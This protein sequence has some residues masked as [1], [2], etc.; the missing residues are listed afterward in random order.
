[1]TMLLKVT[2]PTVLKQ[3]PLQASV[4]PDDQKQTIEV[5]TTLPLQSYAIERNHVKFTLVEPLLLKADQSWSAP[6][7]GSLIKAGQTWY[8]FGEHVQVL[9]DKAVV[10]PAQQPDSVK[11]DVPYKSQLDNQENPTGSCNVTSLAMC[12][13]FLGA[14]RK[15]KD[16]QFEDELYRYAESQDLDRH[17]PHDLASIVEA[18]GCRDEFRTDATVAQVKASLC[19]GKPVVVHGYFTTSGHIVTLVGFDQTGFFVHDPYGEWNDWGYNTQ[20]SGKC[21]HYSYRMMVNTCMPDGSFWVHFLS[22]PPLQDIT[23]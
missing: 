21:L 16:C 19:A 4:L 3:R 7:Y 22:H 6:V 23:D 15:R 13:E 12:L 14:V 11:L 9:E 5:G 18:Y 1:M 2:M 8:A 17:S 10:Y 20:N